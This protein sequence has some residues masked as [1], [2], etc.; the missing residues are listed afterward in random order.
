M[1]KNGRQRAYVGLGSNLGDRISYLEDAVALIGQCPDTEVVKRSHIYETDPVGY[2]EQPAFLNMVVAVETALT[3]EALFSCLLE[4][5]HR[6]GR[7]RDV[8]WGPRTI[9]LDLLLYER[10]TMDTERLLLP[11]P[12]ML[13]R[14]FVLV[15]LLDVAD[16]S[17]IPGY[18]PAFMLELNQQ[19]G[20]RQWTN[21]L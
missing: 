16:A 5:E 4:I 3:P 15:P 20:V 12:R 17:D 21:T 19:G 7:V 9:D 1:T 14:A 18:D 10:V 8:R 11:H 2:V 6:L 13:E